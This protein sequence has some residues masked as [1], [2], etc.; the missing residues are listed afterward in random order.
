MDNQ[1]LKDSGVTFP[2]IGGPMYPCSNPELVAAISEAGALG[3][4][5]PLTLTYVEGYDFREGL[6]YIR[7][8]TKKP[9]GM[10]VLIEKSSKRYE[11][12]MQRWIEIA[13]EEGIRFFITSLGKPDWVVKKV[14]PFGAK[15]Y[16]DV[17]NVHWAEIAID[18]GV[19]GF[20][21][22]NN[23][24]GGHTGEISLDTL[25]QKLQIYGL[26][27]VCA[28]GISERKGYEKARSVGYSAIQMGTRFI[29][30]QECKASDDYKQA[31]V[32][33]QERDIVLTE[34][35]TGIPVSVINTS[36]IKKRDLLPGV[37]ARWLLSHP[38]LKHL[39]RMFYA[40]RSL[41]SLKKGMQSKKADA[42]F[43]QAGKSVAGIKK[44]KSVEEVIQE[45]VSSQR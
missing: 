34:K 27:V 37:I 12:K 5:Q 43:W 23:R 36:S 45:M 29:A 21:A 13:L 24:A 20:V 41:K 39:A 25:I 11:E 32:D 16:H 1:F 7:T 44:I 40:L 10:N 3:V 14:H 8:L 30:T 17:T 28:G 42:Q 22:V 33:A 6:R 4:V 15:V 18:S 2:I 9:I 19:D 31:I 35:I 38:K 26:P